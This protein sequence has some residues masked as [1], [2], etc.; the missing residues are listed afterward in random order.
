MKPEIWGPHLWFI[1][2]LISFEYPERPTEMDKRI[3]HDF[4][5]SLKDVIPC[6]MC[7][8]HY[9][10]HITKYPL[11]PHLDSRDTL[12][13][14]VI[15]VHNFVN[16]SLN[17]PLLNIQ[18]VMEIYSKIKPISPFASINT[19]EIIKKYETK[20]YNKLYGWII[21]LT[22]TIVISRYYFNRFYFML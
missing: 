20:Q 21:I 10:D 6:E 4:Y 2:H 15:Q 7:K 19:P 8:K 14:W 1:M 16:A 11:T 3:Y 17:K 12:V 9:R 13:K 18:Q 5:T 22:I